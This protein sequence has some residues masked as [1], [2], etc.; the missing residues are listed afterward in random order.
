MD[1]L[2]AASTPEGV[3]SLGAATVGPDPACLFS[4]PSHLTSAFASEAHNHPM[5]YFLHPPCTD[6]RRRIRE[7][8]S[9]APDHTAGQ[10]G[11]NREPQGNETPSSSAAHSRNGCENQSQLRWL[12]AACKAQPPI[13]PSLSS[14]SSLA[15]GPWVSLAPS[16]PHHCHP[17]PLSPPPFRPLP[18][19]LTVLGMCQSCSQCL[20]LRL[21]EN[22]INQ[23]NTQKEMFAKDL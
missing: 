10:A 6:K 22:D 19:T 21:R 17:V 23:A 15:R 14:P 8:G 12:P 1:L 16:P 7:A 5:G 18:A 9:L 11:F 13:S 20:L 2:N 3:T 4:P